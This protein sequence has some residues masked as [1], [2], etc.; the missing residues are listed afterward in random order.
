MNSRLNFKSTG[1]GNGGMFA[2]V[3]TILLLLSTAVFAQQGVDRIVV[4]ALS[5]LDKSAVV[6]LPD[7][8]MQVLKPGDR[9]RG[10]DLSLTQVLTDK[11]VL[12]ERSDS[13]GT[14]R[15]V[16]L[17]KAINGSS[18]VEYPEVPLQ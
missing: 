9:I 10:T 14:G 15:V 7:Q 17:H 3:L 12:K 1:R 6:R 2:R 16:W 5:P 18:T 11:L 4:V 8:G 13:T